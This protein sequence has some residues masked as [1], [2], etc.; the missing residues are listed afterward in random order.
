MLN[1]DVR[2]YKDSLTLLQ[3]LIGIHGTLLSTASPL[4]VLSGLGAPDQSG[5]VSAV[6]MTP[7][8]CWGK[9]GDTVVV[10]IDGI[11]TVGQGAQLYTSTQAPLTS[12]PIG[13][14]NGI[15]YNVSLNIVKV[16][17][18][19]PPEVS[20]N[21]LLAGYSYGGALAQAVA[22]LLAVRDLPGRIQVATFGSPRIGNSS[23]ART[24][25]NAT[26]RRYMVDTDP[27]PR[28]P[29]HFFE[30]PTALIAVGFPT[31][32][33]WTAYSQV[34]GGIQLEANGEGSPAV[35]PGRSV[36]ATDVQLAQWLA[37]AYSIGGDPHSQFTYQ[38]RMA[39]SAAKEALSPPAFNVGSGAEGDSTLTE[40]AFLSD[41][42][43][44]AAALTNAMHEESGSMLYVPVNFRPKVTFIAGVYSVVWMGDTMGQ[45]PTKS[46]AKTYAKYLFKFLREHSDASMLFS[47]S[48]TDAWPRWLVA[49]SN[50]LNGFL[51][52]LTVT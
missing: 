17:D 39:L 44:F 25:Q 27:V 42:A 37:S 35:L 32:F 3:A 49:A 43:S 15:A 12:T 21:F 11:T 8:L 22:A 14:I 23:L 33:F 36:P 6:G 52:T 26:V 7:N 13:Q 16:L 51:P 47:G 29:P 1:L 20:S 9:Y 4:N 34:Q 31:A 19:I 2:R 38:S 48:A 50:P 10:L 5:L 40:S 41:K 46:G 24:L 18:A 28:F 30:A 45:F